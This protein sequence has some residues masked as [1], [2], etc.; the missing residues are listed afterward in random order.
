MVEYERYEIYLIINA[1]WAI[2]YIPQTAN[3]TFRGVLTVNTSR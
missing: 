2:L 1:L 3:P